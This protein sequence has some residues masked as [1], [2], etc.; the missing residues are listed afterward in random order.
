MFIK[1]E[2][3]DEMSAYTLFETLNYRGVDLTVTDLLKNY[4]FSLLSESDIRVAKDIWKKI[5]SAIG[6][7]IFPTFLRHYWISRNKLVRQEQLFK[8]IRASIK[9]N[10]NVFTLLRNLESSSA[11]YIALRDP[12]STEW[13]GN[14]E[15][16]KK[17]RELKL[18]GV[19]QQLPLLMIAKEKLTDTEFDK[20]LKL[21]SVIAFRYNIV[22]NRQ[23]NVMEDLYN[24]VALNIYNNTITTTAQISVELK[25]LYVSD[26]DFKN[27]FSTLQVYSYGRDKKLARYVLFE[28]ENL[29]MQGGDR[30]Y[31]YDPATIEHILPENPP[32]AWDSFF[33]PVIQENYTYRL[34]NYSLLE[35]HLNKEYGDKL[36]DVKKIS[37]AKSQYEMPKK[38]LTPDWTPNT[39]EL[40]QQEMSKWASSIWRVWVYLKIKIIYNQLIQAKN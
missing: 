5:A 15:R 6:L 23:A 22:G 8:I 28:I 7:E 1:I 4:L 39:V 24:A 26:K 40:R 20:L 27:D 2:V 10:E 38:I 34:G 35:D 11:L 13:K 21:I 25:S 17:I 33:A 29:L 31:E 16:F 32:V 9:N 3:E 14:R 19:K 36:L 30:D 12:F 18:F 37:Y